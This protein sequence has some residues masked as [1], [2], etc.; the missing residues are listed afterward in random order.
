[1]GIGINCGE[2]VV[3][4]IGSEQRR[5]YGAMGSPINVA[6]RVEAQ[7]A[8]GEILVTPKIHERLG[9]SLIVQSHREVSLKG[10]EEPMILY[11]VVGIKA[12]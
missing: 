12:P 9:Q 7:T 2:L 5:K 10:I 11:Q 6:Y 4:S 3:G 8:G 1:M